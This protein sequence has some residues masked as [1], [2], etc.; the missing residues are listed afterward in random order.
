[1]SAYQKLAVL[2]N[3]HDDWALNIQNYAVDPNRDDDRE[4]A[5]NSFAGK[6]LA[7]ISSRMASGMRK[8]FLVGCATSAKIASLFQNL[9]GISSMADFCIFYRRTEA[10]V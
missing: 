4:P 1:M 3:V 7:G 8:S 5:L 10:V 2:G 6:K 9:Q